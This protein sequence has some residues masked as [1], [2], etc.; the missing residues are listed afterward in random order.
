MC[1]FHTTYV[2]LT[3]VHQ[4]SVG[5]SM[6]G[7]PFPYYLCWPDQGSVGQRMTGVPFPYDLCWHDQGSVGQSMTGVSFPY[8]LCWSDQGPPSLCWPEYDRCVISILPMLV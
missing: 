2:G 7:V 6:T 5:Q 1:H 8:C 3:K 4:G